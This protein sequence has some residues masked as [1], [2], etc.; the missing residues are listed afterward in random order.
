[1]E[2]GNCWL[3]LMRRLNFNADMK[4]FTKYFLTVLGKKGTRMLN[5]DTFLSLLKLERSAFHVWLQLG[6][7]FLLSQYLCIIDCKIEENG[8]TP[9]PVAIKTACF[10][11]N[12]LL[13][14]A[15]NGPSI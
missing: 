12:M 7:F 1:M 9:I 4:W 11:L 8:V 3:P 5:N 6:H 10:A 2:I 14:G 13:A 15:P